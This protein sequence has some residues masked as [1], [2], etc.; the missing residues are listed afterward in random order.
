MQSV[1]NLQNFP[2]SFSKFLKMNIYEGDEQ[3]IHQDCLEEIRSVIGRRNGEI[4][5]EL[6]SYEII[7]CTL[8]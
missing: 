3:R 1:Q 2:H 4:V 8:N 6:L 7:G 5:R